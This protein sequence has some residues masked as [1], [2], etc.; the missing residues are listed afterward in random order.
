MYVCVYVRE[1][2]CVCVCTWLC[3]I[4]VPAVVFDVCA[5]WVAVALCVVW[6]VCCVCCVSVSV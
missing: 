1:V 4:R 5:S 2:V 3:Y 6:C